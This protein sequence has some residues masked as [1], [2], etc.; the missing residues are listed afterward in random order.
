[1]GIIDGIITGGFSVYKKHKQRKRWFQTILSIVGTAFVSFW[2]TLG[3][4]GET[5]LANDVEPVLA[6]ITA[7]FV[8]CLSMAA[9]VLYLWK[10][11]PMTKEIPIAAP[12][13]VEEKVLEGGQTF[14]T[15]AKE[16]KK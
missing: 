10:R 11:S 5:L 3:T 8:A 4:V 6:L 16:K 2:G 1:M 12:M 7:F 9:M 14:T 13:A 15:S